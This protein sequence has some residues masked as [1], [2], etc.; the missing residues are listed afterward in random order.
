MKLT[1]PTYD[2]VLRVAK[3]AVVKEGRVDVDPEA[4]AKGVASQ[5]RNVEVVWSDNGNPVAVLGAREVQSNVWRMFCFS[6][7]EFPS[8][9]LPLTRHLKRKVI[10]GLFAAGAV[11]V[12]GS[13]TDLSVRRWMAVCGGRKD[14][15]LYVLVKGIDWP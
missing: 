1:A 13:A 10:P 7:P 2:V 5:P 8:V 15:E 9:I 6:T 4:V 14:G 3:A 12:E 11:R